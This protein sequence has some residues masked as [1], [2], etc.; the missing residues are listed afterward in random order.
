MP[1]YAHEATLRPHILRPRIATSKPTSSQAPDAPRPPDPPYHPPAGCPAKTPSHSAAS[2][3]H[4]PRPG[5]STPPQSQQLPVHTPAVTTATTA[6]TVPARAPAAATGPART[7]HRGSKPQLPAQPQRGSKPQP[8]P[9]R[10]ATTATARQQ[11]PANPHP[12]S[13]NSHSAAASPSQPPPAPAQITRPGDRPRRPAQATGPGDRPRPNEAYVR[14]RT[15]YVRYVRFIGSIW[16]HILT[17]VSQCHKPTWAQA[18]GWRGWQGRGAAP[19]TCMI[20]ETT[21]QAPR[22]WHC[23]HSREILPKWRPS[24]WRYRMARKLSSRRGSL[25]PPQNHPAALASQPAQPL[26]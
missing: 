18:G 4:C 24:T 7:R 17:Y 21:R 13:H 23:C 20:A 9:T 19:R 10:P 16:G 14:K 6:T 5:S 12:P 25:F 11:A 26:H 22:L 2:A 3:R 15:L 1:S 8:T